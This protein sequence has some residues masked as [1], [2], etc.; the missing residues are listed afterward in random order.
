MSADPITDLPARKKAIREKAHADRNAQPDKDAL[1]RLICQTVVESPAYRSARA[2]MY[3]VDVRSEVRTRDFLPD[4]LR[5]GKKIVVPYCIEGRVLELFHLESM[6]ELALGMYRILEPKAELRSL[7]TK[8]VDVRELDFIL[9]PGVAFTRDGARMGHGFGYYD[10]MLENARADAP[11]VALAF[12]CQL[13]ADLPT[14]AHDI[15]MDQ[16]VTEKAVYP[17]RGR[18]EKG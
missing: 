15:F 12:E 7:Q 13:F 3:F 11:L 2:V 4:A 16:I 8:K 18:G 1:S 6:D 5:H 17:G 10:K 14:E 9:V